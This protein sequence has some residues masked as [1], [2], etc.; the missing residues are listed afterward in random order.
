MSLYQMQK[1]LY[2]LNRDR[3]V[4]RQYRADLPR[5]SRPV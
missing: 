4:Q 3:D 1:L 2:D 5:R